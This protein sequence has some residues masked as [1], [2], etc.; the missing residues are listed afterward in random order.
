[1]KPNGDAHADVFLQMAEGKL[2]DHSHH[3][4]FTATSGVKDFEA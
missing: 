3:V 1:M 4:T 2:E